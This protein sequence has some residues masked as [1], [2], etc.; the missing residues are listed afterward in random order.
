MNR[1]TYWTGLRETPS[2]AVHSPTGKQNPI[3]EC[4]CDPD[5]TS[6]ELGANPR[7]E[8]ENQLA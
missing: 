4:A 2:A 6:G 7:T 3:F 1:S 8:S 5:G